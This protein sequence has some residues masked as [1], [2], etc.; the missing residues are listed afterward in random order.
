MTDIPN[1][2]NQNTKNV[3]ISNQKSEFDTPPQ[4]V[5]TPVSQTQ[6]DSNIVIKKTSSGFRLFI[7][8][9][10]IL[11]IL[12]WVFAG[13]IY[14]S[15]D[16]DLSKLNFDQ[17]KNEVSQ[18]ANSPSESLTAK[19]DVK[20]GNVVRI[21]NDREITIIDKSDFKSTGVAGFGKVTQ[22][23]DGKLL[24]IESHP[25]SLDASI[26]VSDVNG[27]NVRK[28]SNLKQ[29][30][31][32]SIKSDKI[33][34]MD[35][36]GGD[37]SD[38]YIFDFNTNIENNLTSK[39]QNSDNLYIFKL[40]SWSFRDKGVDCQYEDNGVIYSCSINLDSGELSK[41]NIVEIDE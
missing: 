39:L 18:E 33:A 11:S 15:D 6:P 30:C 14:F 21:E 16:L 17:L 28:I 1:E 40:L 36:V 31:L 26:Y 8:I 29:N 22:S 25:P 32:W 24:C 10:I 2:I 41:S 34:Y 19:F 13:Y 7:F 37:K 3:N 9:I 12:T 23:Y 35:L 27:A 4:I 38:I 20:N 5:N